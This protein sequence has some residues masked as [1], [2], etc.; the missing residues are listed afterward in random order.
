MIKS[1]THSPEPW[2]AAG[3]GTEPPPKFFVT[4]R[5]KL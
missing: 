1:M 3:G 2:V 5:C 4:P